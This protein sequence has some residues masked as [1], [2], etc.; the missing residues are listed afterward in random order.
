M[1]GPAP[2]DPSDKDSFGAP[3]LALSTFWTLFKPKTQ[4]FLA[5]KNA[6]TKVQEIQLSSALSMF[7]S[8]S[9]RHTH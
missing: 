4:A 1:V 3:R 9:T 2:Q 7:F 6:L 5:E 8:P